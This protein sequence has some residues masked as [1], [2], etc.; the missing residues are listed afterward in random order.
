[1][2]PSIILQL[3][4]S[5]EHY[6][7]EFVIHNLKIYF[8]FFNKGVLHYMLVVHFG[9]SRVKLVLL[10]THTY[11]FRTHALEKPEKKLP[12]C[13]NLCQLYDCTHFHL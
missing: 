4:V 6:K 5:R 9:T 10:E 8:Y 1:M 12:K 2:M 11:V 3:L 13:F 7:L